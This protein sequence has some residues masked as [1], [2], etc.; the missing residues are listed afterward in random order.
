MWDVQRPIGP[1]R[2]PIVGENRMLTLGKT[3]ER[4]ESWGPEYQGPAR[5][6]KEVGFTLEKIP[7]QGRH[8]AGW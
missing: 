4:L 2:P 8:E 6:G 1:R 5:C 7:L 3:S